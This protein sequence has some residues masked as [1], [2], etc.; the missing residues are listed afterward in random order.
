MTQFIVFSLDFYF[1]LYDVC[2]DSLKFVSV[3]LKFF[4]Q[5]TE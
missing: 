2:L 1:T 4:P 3:I 5:S